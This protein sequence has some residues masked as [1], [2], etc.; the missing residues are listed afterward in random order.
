MYIDAIDR[1]ILD[2]MDA[3]HQLIINSNDKNQ[4]HLRLQTNN[5]RLRLKDEMRRKEEPIT[6]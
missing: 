1:Q 2:N 3:N 5:E 6:Y 4:T